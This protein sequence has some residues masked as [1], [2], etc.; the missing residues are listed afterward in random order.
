MDERERRRRKRKI[1]VYTMRFLTALAAVGILTLLI[2][3]GVGIV[4]LIRGRARETMAVSDE[5]MEVLN[6]LKEQM[7]GKEFTLILDAGHGGNDVGT[8]SPDYYEKDIN[9]DIVKEMKEML[10]Y[11]GVEVALTRDGDETVTLDERSSFANDSEGDRFVSIHCNYCEEDASVAGLECYYWADSMIGESYAREIVSA[12]EGSGQI[13]VRGIKTEDFHVLRETKIPAVLVETGY[14]SNKEDRENLYDA[15]Y[16]K[17][18]SVYLVKG[19]IEGYLH[20][21]QDMPSE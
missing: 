20:S 8:G 17:T 16:Q 5:D 11:C 4:R 12:V 6:G 1:Q 10:E 2:L 19:I 21:V 18:L 7:K 9:M 3:A 13:A 14:I 15:E